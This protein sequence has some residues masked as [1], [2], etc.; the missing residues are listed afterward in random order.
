MTGGGFGGSAIVLVDEA[1]VE[2][3]GDAVVEAFAGAG[4]REPRVFEALPSAGAR[5]VS[6]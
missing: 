6:A 2:K 1:G 5:R 4:H 3:V